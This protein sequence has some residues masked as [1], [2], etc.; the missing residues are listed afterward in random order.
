MVAIP[1]VA[2]QSVTHR[3]VVQLDPANPGLAQ[4]VRR[5]RR[6]GSMVI[7]ARTVHELQTLCDTSAVDVVILPFNTASTVAS[8]MLPWL[9]KR[10][11]SVP[12]ILLASAPTTHQVTF[13]LE[14][15]VT[16][17]LADFRNPEQLRTALG[18]AWEERDVRMLAWLATREA[19]SN[20]RQRVEQSRRLDEV[21][22][23]L[24]VLWQPLEDTKTGLR[25]SSEALVRAPRLGGDTA[26]PLLNL[27][28]ELGRAS[29]VDT[30]VARHVAA[31]LRSRPD[32][33]HVFVNV[34]PST[35]RQGYL[36]GDDHPFAG[37]RD[38]VIL[39]IP[40]ACFHSTDTV[41]T[42]QIAQLHNIKQ[43]FA[44]N[45]LDLWATRHSPTLTV[46]PTFVKIAMTD[47]RQCSQQPARARWVRFLLEMLHRQNTSAVAVGVA[48]ADDRELATRL[49]LD[50]LQGNFIA[51]PSPTELG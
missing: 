29:E 49:G 41:L 20:R 40:S 16:G 25:C 2:L 43:R 27:A 37:L 39:D 6:M 11:P 30:R 14:H 12:I 50:L 13:A 7:T 33:H 24:T 38:R 9:A 15:G 31:T 10:H 19:D 23:E 28:R 26:G 47:L 22:S 4:M 18:H 44:A 32:W 46:R 21:M 3:V 45:D 34:E 36:S 5:I 42:E 51:P 17:I 35:V 48:S 1:S 8:S